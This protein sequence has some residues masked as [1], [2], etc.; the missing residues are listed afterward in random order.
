MTHESLALRQAARRAFLKRAGTATAIALTIGFDWAG[1]TRRAAAAI[2]PSAGAAFAPNAFLRISSDNSVTVIAKHVEMGQGAYTGIATIVAEELDADWSRVRVESAPADA[3]RYANLAFG[4]LQ[5]HRRQFSH[6]QFLDAASRGRA[7][8]L[9][10]CCS[11]R[12]QKLESARWGA[13]D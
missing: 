5:G 13:H 10:R 9:A 6:G 3:K 12:R 7:P 4:T 8:R 1:P 2:A 11:P